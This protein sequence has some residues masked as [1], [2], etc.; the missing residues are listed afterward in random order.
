MLYFYWQT[1]ILEHNEI[2]IEGGMEIAL[3]MKNKN[4][5][6]L[7]D[8]N[9]NRFG[10]SVQKLITEFKKNEKFDVLHSFR[11]VKLLTTGDSTKWHR[12][13]SFR[14]ILPVQRCS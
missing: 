14:Y 8:L 12:K 1:L 3:A 4:H 6:Q 9:G 11:L 13:F 2:S 5:L 10:G 7:V